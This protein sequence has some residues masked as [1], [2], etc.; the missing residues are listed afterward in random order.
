VELVE[1][2][3]GILLRPTGKQYDLKTLLQA[4]RPENLHKAE[5]TGEA[6]GKEA[7]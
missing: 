4:V 3:D 2:A 1:H 6:V 7:W 5:E